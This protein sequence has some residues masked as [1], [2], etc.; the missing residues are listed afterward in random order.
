MLSTKDLLSNHSTLVR[1]GSIKHRMLSTSTASDQQMDPQIRHEA[2]RTTNPLI[3]PHNSLSI[4]LFIFP[5]KNSTA[6]PTTPFINAQES[7]AQSIN[8]SRT[9]SRL[10]DLR[11]RLQSLR[12]L[13]GVYIVKLGAVLGYDSNQ[14]GLNF[15][16]SANGTSLHALSQE[17]C[18]DLAQRTFVD[19]WVPLRSLESSVDSKC[20]SPN[21]RSDQITFNFIAFIAS[22][23]F[24][25]YCF[26]LFCNSCWI[27]LEPGRC[28]YWPH[29][30]PLIMQS[31]IIVKF[32]RIFFI[33]Q[34]I[35]CVVRL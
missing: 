30:I 24:F 21:H 2:H 32:L 27:N 34:L 23:R 33:F 18:I 9:H 15:G 6:L 31:M 16:S 12:R 4:P 35:R 1:T 8:H 13:T 17:V 28:H 10:T 14:I 25:I 29:H 19:R 20:T 5:H 22:A 11:L 3:H 7:V 26:Y